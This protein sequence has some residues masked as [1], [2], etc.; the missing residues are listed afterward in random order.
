MFIPIRRD[1][2]LYRFKGQNAYNEAVYSRKGIPFGWGPLA[3]LQIRDH[4]EVRADKSASK[5][6]AEIDAVDYRMV[7]QREVEPRNG[8]KIVLGTGEHMR[9]VQVHRRYNIAGVLHHWEISCVAD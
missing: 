4:T 8:D 7:I 1:G 9:V 5:S 2:M 3:T 6:R